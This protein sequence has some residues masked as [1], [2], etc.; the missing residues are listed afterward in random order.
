MHGGRDDLAAG[1]RPFGKRPADAEFLVVRMCINAHRTL[2]DISVV[3]HKI[4][5]LL[6]IPGAQSDDSSLRSTVA[7][8]TALAYRLAP[9]SA[10]YLNFSPDHQHLVA[11]LE[12][13]EECF[14][15]R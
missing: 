9:L 6:V 14:Y 8:S 15:R 4:V 2:G 10:G 7:A 13:P 3:T 1:T 5:S 11:D 12:K